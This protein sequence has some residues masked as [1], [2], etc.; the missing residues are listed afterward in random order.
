MKKLVSIFFIVFFLNTAF[1]QDRGSSGV[2]LKEIIYKEN[3]AKVLNFSMKD[4]DRVFFEFSDKKATANLV[5]TKEAFYKYTIQIAAFSDRLGVLYP[6]QKE[7]AEASKK[8]WFA[9]SYEDYLLS[10]QS[11]R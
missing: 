4:F 10:K 9:E 1:V 2:A 5:L 11:Q 7:M 6:D 8:K 3:R